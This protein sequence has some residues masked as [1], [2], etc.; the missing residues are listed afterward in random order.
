VPLF[1]SLLIDFINL[2]AT[3]TGVDTFLNRAN[4]AISNIS[5]DES[6]Y[7][8]VGKR[9]TEKYFILVINK[10]KKALKTECQ[11]S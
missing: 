6:S 8:H 10:L 7:L 1:A 11:P 9:K 5:T 4:P 2:A 3:Q